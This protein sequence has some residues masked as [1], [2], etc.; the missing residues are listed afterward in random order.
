M[1]NI[2]WKYVSPLKDKFKIDDLEIKYCYQ[3]PDDLKNCIVEHNAGVPVPC[4][5][6]F[7]GNRD[8]VF[9]GLLSYNADDMD[10]IYE[11]VELFRKEGSS[12]LSMFPF[13]IDPAGN[14]FCVK[15]KRIVFYDHETER[16]FP[17]CDTFTQFLGMLHG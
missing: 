9:G 16:V 3:L 15:D 5:I 7:R 8:K 10:N 11:F 1:E 13:G 17:I 14:F 2:Q 6:D 4:L 12:L